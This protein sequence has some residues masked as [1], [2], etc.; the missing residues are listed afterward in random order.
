MSDASVDFDTFFLRGDGILEG[1]S[2][3]DLSNMSANGLGLG[4]FG[5]S[6]F[7]AV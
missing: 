3:F 6:D 2:R 7:L 4:I 5:M 1:L